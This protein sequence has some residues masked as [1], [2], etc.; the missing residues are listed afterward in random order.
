MLETIYSSKVKASYEDP[1]GHRIILST[2]ST[3]T[4]ENTGLKGNYEN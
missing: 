1:S 3:F 2:L 4:E